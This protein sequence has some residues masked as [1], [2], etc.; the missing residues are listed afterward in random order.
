MKKKNYQPEGFELLEILLEQS[1]YQNQLLGGIIN[2]LD[3]MVCQLEKISKQTCHSLSEHHLQTNIQ[4]AL[5]KDIAFIFEIFKHQ[6]PSEVLKIKELEE[7]K[8]KI[9][10]C[11]PSKKDESSFCSY[12]PCRK[13]SKQPPGFNKSF[14]GV[15]LP[16]KV[17]GAPYPPIVKQDIPNRQPNFRPNRIVTKGQ[18]KGLV[19]ETPSS[20][21]KQMGAADD[22]PD[23]VV[24]EKYTLNNGVSPASNNAA[25]ISGGDN[26]NV[27]MLTGNWY[28]QYSTDGGLTFTTLNPTTIFPNTLAGGFC[29]DQIIQYVPNIDRFIWLLQY[30]Q[31]T[32]GNNAYRLASAS[33]QDIIRS[34]CSAWT[35]WDL[36]SASFNIGTDWMDYPSVSYGNNSLY[37]SFDVLDSTVDSSADNGLV[38]VR[39]PLS[40]I[41][42]SAPINFRYTN[43][44]DSAVAWGSNVSQNTGDEVFWAG[45]VDNSTIRIFNF[46]ESSTNYGWRDIDINNWPNNAL[47]S[48]GPNGNNWLAWGVPNNAIIGITRRQNELWL[49]WTA[50]NGDGGFGGFNF[51]HPHVQLIKIN[52]GAYTLIEQM[53]IWN[54]DHAFGYP[55][56]ATNSDNEVGI[57]LGWG[58]GGSLNANSAVGIMGDYVVW[59]RDG[60][61][62]THNRW[63]DYVTVRQAAPDSRFFAGFGF[64]IID[65]ST[66]A[67]AN[68]RFDPYYVLFGRQSKLTPPIS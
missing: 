47:S 2:N 59:Y 19:S 16:K 1:K 12:E 46:H 55:S 42:Q 4:K 10:E 65:T 44:A 27:V 62:W 30:Q 64:V 34:N 49:S 68:H 67:G 35:Y 57:C 7:L 32:G 40:E 36:T 3:I 41:Q 26:G 38:V 37:F 28:V 56:L 13:P 11:C 66:P 51:P 48:I 8:N 61:T 63:G 53:Q 15:S 24:F 33:P 22:A 20:G 6:N 29:C 5:L 54:P 21:L 39:I 17:E 18:F 14:E 52:I 25:D 45:H 9:E 58:G 43:P 50:S 23:P 60:S 31:A